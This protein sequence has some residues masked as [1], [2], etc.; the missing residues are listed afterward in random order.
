MDRAVQIRGR[1][2]E[3]F[4]FCDELTRAEEGLQSAEPDWEEH[5]KVI[6]EGM[7]SGSWTGT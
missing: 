6:L 1:N 7:M 2:L 4:R 5:K 3:F